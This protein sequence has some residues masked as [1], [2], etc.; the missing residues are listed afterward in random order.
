MKGNC[1]SIYSHECSILENFSVLLPTSFPAAAHLAKCW[2][3]RRSF[4]HCA[5][6]GRAAPRLCCHWLKG[7]LSGS[8]RPVLSCFP[9]LALGDTAR[10][11]SAVFLEGVLANP[12]CRAGRFAVVT[13]SLPGSAIHSDSA[14]P[15]LVVFPVSFFPK[16]CR[17]LLLNLGWGHQGGSCI[18][19]CPIECV[20]GGQ[21]AELNI[22]AA[23]A[24]I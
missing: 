9:L 8:R 16:E 18:S 23:E 22:Q 3:Q 2:R 19:S 15:G 20:W 11:S 4:F 1:R 21:S 12:R 14:A 24:L 13:L 6:E 7:P 10:S 5:P 17:A